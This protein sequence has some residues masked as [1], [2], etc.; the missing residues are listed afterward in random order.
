MPLMKV[1]FFTFIHIPI[2]YALNVLNILLEYGG[3]VDDCLEYLNGE[4]KR[5]RDAY[6]END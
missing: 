5:I 6:K 2:F 4:K 3:Q 1:H